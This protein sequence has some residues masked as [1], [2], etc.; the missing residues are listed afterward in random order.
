MQP[1]SGPYIIVID[2]I[3]L[4]LGCS[5]KTALVHKVVIILLMGV[6]VHSSVFGSTCHYIIYMLAI[7]GSQT[8]TD[9]IT[10][11]TLNFTEGS[12]IHSSDVLLTPHALII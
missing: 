3:F 7:R 12:Y 8:P 4:A 6:V 2:A 10:R 5:S 11:H 9:S 1:G